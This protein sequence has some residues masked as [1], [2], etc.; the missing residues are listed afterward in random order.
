MKLTLHEQVVVGHSTNNCHDKE[1]VAN[2]GTKTV[3]FDGTTYGHGQHDGRD[4][5]DDDRRWSVSPLIHPVR[6][7]KRE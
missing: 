1:Q 4:E 3:H 2:S 7:F 6:S 5:R